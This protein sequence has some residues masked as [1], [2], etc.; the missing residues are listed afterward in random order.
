MISF[1][2][3]DSM[4]NFDKSC[5]VYKFNCRCN[6]IYIVRTMHHFK[7]RINEHI[8]RCVE[9]YITRTNF[10]ILKPVINTLKR[11]VI[12][13]HL[14][15]NTNFAVIYNISMFSTMHQHANKFDLT[16]IEVILVHLYKSEL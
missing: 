5:I 4:P 1:D 12:S 13:E 2:V 8:L 15:N 9:D 10:Q 14:I 7:I 3:K 16:T 6:M 11:S